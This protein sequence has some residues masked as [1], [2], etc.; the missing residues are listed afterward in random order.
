MHGTAAPL[1]EL[2]TLAERYNTMLLVDE[3]HATGVLG[4]H[5][6]GICELLHAEQGLSVRVGTLSKALGGQGGFV[7]GPQRLIDWLANRARPY[8]FSTAAPAVTA[9]AGL[10]ALNI[11]RTEPERRSFLRQL[12]V[13]FRGKLTDAKVP[14]TGD[15][16]IVSIILDEPQRTVA[17]AA[18]LRRRGFFVPA[19][20]P[21]SVPSGQ[22]MLRVSLTCLH[23]EEHLENL[24]AALAAITR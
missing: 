24:A 13:L 8:I 18:E 6:R 22:S 14:C 7:C 17:A 2:A 19:I 5:G 12:S 20:R 10:A 15:F 23:R 4:E 21:P 3:A 1:S 16:H 11:I 9:A